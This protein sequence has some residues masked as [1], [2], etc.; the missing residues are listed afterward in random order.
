MVPIHLLLRHLFRQ[1]IVIVELRGVVAE[2]KHAYRCL[3]IVQR[4]HHPRHPRAR[5]QFPMRDPIPHVAPEFRVEHVLRA[6]FVLR[7]SAVRYIFGHVFVGPGGEHQRNVLSLFVPEVVDVL[8]PDRSLAPH[9]L[10]ETLR[11]GRV[12]TDHSVV[13]VN[14]FPEFVI[15]KRA[16]VTHH[17]ART[18]RLAGPRL[19]EEVVAF[20]DHF[21]QVLRHG[22]DIVVLA[23]GHDGSSPT[24]DAASHFQQ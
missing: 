23:K 16:T 18:Q 4:E 24:T 7:L 13:L 19:L 6:R 14:I 21:G 5:L 8:D 10:L 12:K 20:G 17:R 22:L 2:P 9:G 15:K 11:R 3:A 1:H